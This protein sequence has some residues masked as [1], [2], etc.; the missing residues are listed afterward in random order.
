MD[1]E[2]ASLD[3]RVLKG[4]QQGSLALSKGEALTL[5]IYLDRSVIEVYANDR[6][7]G[8]LRVYPTRGDSLG[9][10]AFTEGGDVSLAHI[11]AWELQAPPS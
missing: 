11:D 10:D 3:A 1:R 4:T 8:T 7:A 2:R 9:V 5:R 6:V